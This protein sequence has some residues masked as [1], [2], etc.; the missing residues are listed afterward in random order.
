VVLSGARLARVAAAKAFYANVM[1]LTTCIR[2]DGKPV[3]WHSPDHALGLRRRVNKMVS[4]GFSVAAITAEMEKCTPLCRSCHMKED[5]R[6]D[7]LLKNGAAATARRR[8]QPPKSCAECERRSKPLRHGLCGR[9]YTRHQI[10]TN[11]P[12]VVC[13][14][15][16][17][18][19]VLEAR[20]MS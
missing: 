7:E 8:M 10:A 3:D 5:G 12:S 4:V 11:P 19:H 20:A 17:D 9:C 13:G 2:C 6:L 14:L 16:A 18:V 15:R 1:A